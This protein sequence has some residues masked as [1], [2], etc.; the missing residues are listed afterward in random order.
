[1]MTSVAAVVALAIWG[2]IC[3]GGALLGG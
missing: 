3:A 2:I 1:M